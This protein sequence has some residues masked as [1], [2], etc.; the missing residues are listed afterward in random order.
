M[1]PKLRAVDAVFVPSSEHGRLLVLRCPQG[2]TDG[3][4]ALPPL[5]VPIIRRFDGAQSVDAIARA[6]SLEIGVEVSPAVVERLARSLDERGFLEGEAFERRL[7][8]ARLAFRRLRTRPAAHAGGAYSADAAALIDYIERDCF[9]AAIPVEDDGGGSARALIAPHID[10]WRGA[11]GYGAAYLWLRDHLDATCDTVVVVGTSH[12]PMTAPFALCRHSFET[13]LGVVPS[14]RDLV[15]ELARDAPFDVFADEL[16]HR[17]EH[18]VEL[19]LPFLLRAARGRPLRIVPLLAS[20]DTTSP[21]PASPRRDRDVEAFVRALGRVVDRSGALIIA[22]ADL[23][24]VGPRFGDATAPT[25]PERAALAARD[26]A[27]LERAR[28][29]DAD[30]FFADVAADVDTRR[31][32]GLS[33]IWVMLRALDDGLCG[34]VL[35]YGQAVAPEDGSVV[36]YG[37]VAYATPR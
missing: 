37:A 10:P 1:I 11:R 27:S 8:A 29:G 16:N 7:A 36:S 35:H 17:D 14:A 24:H 9:A 33:P 25:A 21:S 13:P 5:A 19:Q 2:L 32:C 20:L 23:A 12:A 15:D 34:R 30:G 6:A 3:E 22:A 28:M 4:A 18:S 31:I 26:E